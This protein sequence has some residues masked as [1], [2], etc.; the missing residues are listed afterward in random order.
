VNLYAPN[1]S[2][3]SHLP[4]PSD[5]LVMGCPADISIGSPR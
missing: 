3:S 5:P 1:C 2:V 4:D